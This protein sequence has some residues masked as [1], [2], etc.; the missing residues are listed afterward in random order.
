AAR[1]RWNGQTEH[2]SVAAFAQVTLDLM[3]LGAPPKLLD[4][5]NRDAR[6]E[7]RHAEL[8]FS[9]ARAIDGQVEGPRAFPQARE[10]DPR[11]LTRTLALTQLAVKSLIDGALYEGLSARVIARL[12][13]RTDDVAIR[14]LL[15]ELAADE[16]RHS[17]SAWDVIDWCIAEGGA[18]VVQA[19]RGAAAGMGERYAGNLPEGA[20]VGAWERF[21]IPGVALEQD[22]YAKART[23]VQRRVT[24]LTAAR[25]A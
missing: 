18:P 11:P 9:L 22:E 12:A 21:G 1:W 6:D 14:S 5:A 4:A 16:G 3:A 10:L 8:C 24:E 7:I 20:M 13:K 2:A 19:L 23:E 25:V 17:A 15:L